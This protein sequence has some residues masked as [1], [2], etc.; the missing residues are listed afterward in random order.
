MAKEYPATKTDV[1]NLQTH[2]DETFSPFDLSEVYVAIAD[3]ANDEVTVTKGG[4]NTIDR[5][6]ST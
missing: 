6:V 2:I 4:L 5:I 3:F 1:T